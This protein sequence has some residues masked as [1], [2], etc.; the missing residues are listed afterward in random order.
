MDSA[1]KVSFTFPVAGTLRVHDDMPVNLSDWSFYFKTCEKTGYVDTLIIEVSNIPKEKWPT[2]TH[3]GQIPD[4][5][6]PRF[7]L[8][9]NP[10]AF[11]FKSIEPQV[12]NLESYL[13]VYGLEEIHLP[14]LEV[15][16]TEED[17]D[18]IDKGMSLGH[19]PS[20]RDQE[21]PRDQEPQCEP[22]DKNFL[23]RCIVASNS[24]GLEAAALAHFRIGQSHFNNQRYIEAIRNLYICVESLFANGHTSERKT[25][26]E[27][28]KSTDLQKA[29]ESVLLN[30]PNKSF[31]TIFDAKRTK[32]PDLKKPTSFEG[33]LKF[34]FKLRGTIQHA[35]G[36]TQG[37]WHPSQQ[38]EFEHEAICVIQLVEEICCNI[39]ER[40]T[41]ADSR[42]PSDF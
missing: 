16:W 21:P 39:V 17:N 22:L 6:I 20:T 3:I 9:E 27:F 33:V 29:V 25:I 19:S 34:L 12:I 26:P 23:A 32:W 28:K 13:S 8:A 1:L 24:A 18:V 30:N 11:Q 40:D 38:H 5:E 31:D 14:G 41:A 7:P 35:N 2:L 15:V 36:F 37:K 42:N 4:A 10:N